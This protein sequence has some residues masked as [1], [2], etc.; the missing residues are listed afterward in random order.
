MGQKPEIGAVP[1][2]TP[3]PEIG[4]TVNLG[5]SEASGQK[6]RNQAAGKASN[7][8]RLHEAENGLKRR[9]R[10]RRESWKELPACPLP[11]EQR[12]GRYPKTSLK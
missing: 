10:Q 5:S 6:S 9:R 4:Q 2:K 8:S 11:E 1:K 3:W 12:K 7:E